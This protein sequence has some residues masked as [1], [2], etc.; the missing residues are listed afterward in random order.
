MEDIDLLIVRY[1][2]N[3]ATLDEKKILENWINSSEDN[4]CYF[5]RMVKTWEKSHIY[6]QNDAIAEDYFIRF[7]QLLHRRKTRRLLYSLSAA[8]AV[9]FFVLV[10][11]F[12][13]PTSNVV[14]LSEATVDQKKEVVLPDGSIVWLNKNSSIEYPNNFIS[15]REVFLTGE[16][17]FDVTK[18]NGKPFTVKTKELTVQ[19]LGT[20]FVVTDYNDEKNAEAVL[21]TGKIK[22]KVEEKGEVF[23]LQPGQMVTHNCENGETQLQNVDVHQF[24]DWIKNSLVFENTSMKNVI[25]QLEKWYGIKIECTD[26]IILQTP[27]T[28]TI[29]KEA[30]EE[31]LNTLQIVVPFIWKE[32]PNQGERTSIITIL[33]IE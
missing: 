18:N 3:T 23:T 28:I 2:D 1:L 24:T 13:V 32:K 15:N 19:V 30:K 4:R 31:V 25:T 7:R 16:A 14:L 11:R 20:R 22:L 12:F 8:A 21:E 5:V 6:L 33:P 10:I 29:D 26:E 27:V 17:F 9:A